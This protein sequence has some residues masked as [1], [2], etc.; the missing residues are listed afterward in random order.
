M[1]WWPEGWPD[2]NIIGLVVGVYAMVLLL[3]MSPFLIWYLLSWLVCLIVTPFAWLARSTLGRPSPVIAYWE[4]NPWAEW[5]GSADGRGA[6]DELAQHV[7]GEVAQFAAPRSLAAPRP[8]LI[9]LTTVRETPIVERI[10]ARWRARGTGA[11]G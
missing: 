3:I 6:A 1:E 11:N 8:E 2:D 7:A 9:E 5:W 4:E 10:A